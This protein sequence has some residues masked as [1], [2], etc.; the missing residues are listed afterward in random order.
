MPKKVYIGGLE[1]DVTSEELKEVFEEF[2]E[3]IESRVIKDRYTKQ[4]RGF[5]FITFKREED[6]DT[7]IAEADGGEL[8]GVPIRVR[9]AKERKSR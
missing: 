1:M 7:A 6:A 5:A 2:G 3:I 4:S 8:D 9:E